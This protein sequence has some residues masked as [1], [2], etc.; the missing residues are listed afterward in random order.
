MLAHFATILTCVLFTV[1]FVCCNLYLSKRFA[2]KI[3][4]WVKSQPYECGEEVKGSPFIQFNPR[5]YVFALAFLIFDVEIVFMYP[6]ALAFREM[7]QAS[8]GTLIVLE[9]L[10]FLLILFFGL[11][12][13]W[14]NHDLTWVANIEKDE[15]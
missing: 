3:Q 2:P 1:V 10:A 12:Y 15:A 5:Y 14:A 13:L 4:N 6:C 9:I 8:Q 11:V 7:L